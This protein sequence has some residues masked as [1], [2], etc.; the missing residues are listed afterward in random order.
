MKYLVVGH[1]FG[2]LGRGGYH[3]SKR[4][5]EEYSTYCDFKED[6]K[7]RNLEE[8]NEK[9]KKIIFRT[10][11][12]RCYRYSVNFVRLRSI[13]HIF[14]LRAA[15]LNPLY[16]N[17]TNG[18]YYYRMHSG[19]DNYVPM[20]TDFP[21]LPYPE[22]ECFGFYVRNWLTPDSFHCFLEILDSL[23]RK[24]KVATMGDFS[25]EIKSHKNVLT[26]LHTNNN[27]QFFS[28]VTHYFYPT[29]KKFIDPFPHS[30]LEASQSGRVV[31]LPKIERTFKDGIDDLKDVIPWYEKYVPDI[32]PQGDDSILASKIWKKFYRKV[33]SDGWQFSFDRNKYKNF[34]SFIEGEVI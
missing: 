29:S 32:H 24:V 19:F 25:S 3:V 8:L 16:K 14:Y 21:R 26:H 28:T 17:C 33:F 7:A 20:I 22:D 2:E 5:C 4:F 27:T 13:N 11:V 10:Q 12:P 18:F 23:K 1:K 34:S 6:R 15:Y 31:I 9:Y 30:V